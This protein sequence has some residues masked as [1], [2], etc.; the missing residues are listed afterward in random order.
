MCGKSIGKR[1][2]WDCHLSRYKT[3]DLL[4]RLVKMI[5]VHR[6][7][8]TRIFLFT[9]FPASL[10]IYLNQLVRARTPIFRPRLYYCNF[11]RFLNF[12][13][14]AGSPFTEP[15]FHR[16]FSRYHARKVAKTCSRIS[17]PSPLRR[18]RSMLG[19]IT[20][21]LAFSQAAVHGIKCHLESWPTISPITIIASAAFLL[22]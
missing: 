2:I 5:Q 8:L 21:R 15:T 19:R 3:Y 17:F 10:L 12:Y 18:G 7:S 1:K 11:P 4:L 14:H 20:G 13:P 16:E 6:E 9:P 22:S